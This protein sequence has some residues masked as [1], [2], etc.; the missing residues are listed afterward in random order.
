MQILTTLFLILIS[1]SS[2]SFTRT[3]E[4]DFEGEHYKVVLT[5][6]SKM[7]EKAKNIGRC[8][9]ACLI[10][11]SVKQLKELKLD[12]EFSLITRFF[13][14]EQ[15]INFALALAQSIPYEIGQWQTAITTIHRKKAD[16]KGKT[17]LLG[18]LLILIGIPEE[19][20]EFLQY[21]GH[22]ALGVAPSDGK[23]PKGS[24][25]F[26]GEKSYYPLD[27]AFSGPAKWGMLADDL[28]GASVEF[29]R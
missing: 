8:D 24:F 22:I 4:W 1:G 27:A 11:Q 13:S 25:Y 28:N 21:P 6:D 9:K 29:L 16:C 20:I 14:E 15:K 7:I 3:L 23:E 10:K 5:L 2:V 26:D 12:K 19:N 18:S 17:I